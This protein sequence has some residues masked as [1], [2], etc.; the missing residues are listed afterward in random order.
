[1]SPPGDFPEEPLAD[2]PLRVE[3]P[4]ALPERT[5][6]PARAP[7]AAPLASRAVAFVGDVATVLLAVAAALLAATAAAGAR[8]PTP[9]P[10]GLAWA[11]V[12]ALYFSFFAITVPLLLFGKTVGLA[13]SG[14]VVRPGETGRRLTFSESVRRWAGTLL[15]AATFGI[16]LLFTMRDRAR[17]TPADRLSG[18]ELVEDG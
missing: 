16:P 5:Q 4:G 14:L 8:A 13:L 18:R 17:P 6:G 12:F 11:G 1:M 10:R 7:E 3:R 15:T 9:T 2:L